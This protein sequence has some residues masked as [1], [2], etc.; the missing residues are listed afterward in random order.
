MNDVYEFRRAPGKGAIWLG[1]AT[2]A[3]LLFVMALTDAKLDWL[4]WGAGAVTLTWMVLPRPVAGI[5]VDDTHLVLSAWQNPQTI[6]LDDIDHLK[7]TRESLESDFKIVLRDGREMIALAGD[8]PDLE[9]LVYV[10][11]VRGIP[12]RDVY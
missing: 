4:V 11:A 6:P 1:S 9:T 12:V 5:K 2:V 3:V 10:M 7:A 8:M